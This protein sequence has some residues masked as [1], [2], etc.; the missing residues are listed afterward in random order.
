MQ[1][2]HWND[3]AVRLDAHKERKEWSEDGLTRA[4]T[5][6]EPKGAQVLELNHSEPHGFA[7]TLI[8]YCMML[9]LGV[10]KHKPFL[11][12]SLCQTQVAKDGTIVE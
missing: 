2:A 12:I 11:I 10:S 5:N 6:Q 9:L 7:R 4:L 8:G 1:K 3:I